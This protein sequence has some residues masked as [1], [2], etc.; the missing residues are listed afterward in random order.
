MAI[1]NASH[2]RCCVLPMPEE[3]HENAPGCALISATRSR[4]LL[5]ATVGATATTFGTTTMS[6]IGARS[7]MGS[8]AS[9]IMC[10]AIAC[11]EF[12]AT[13]SV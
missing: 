6:A 7:R 1:A 12:V 4:M 8:K 5:A 3:P 11:A 2:A 10:G 13:S 9:F